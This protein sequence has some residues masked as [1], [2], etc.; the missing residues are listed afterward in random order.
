[1]ITQPLVVHRRWHDV[2]A[3]GRLATKSFNPRTASPAAD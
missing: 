1:M 3:G 2:L